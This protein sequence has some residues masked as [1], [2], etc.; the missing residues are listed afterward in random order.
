MKERTVSQRNFLGALL[1][2]MI[3]ILAFGYLH[4]IALPPG[5]FLGVIIGWWYQEIGQ[6]AMKE[7]HQST[8]KSLELWNCLTIFVPALINKLKETKFDI[9]PYIKIF[10]SLLF[11]VIWIL[12]RPIACIRWLKAHPMNRAYSVKTLAVIMYIALNAVWIVSLMMCWHE[13]AQLVGKES[14]MPLFYFLGIGTITMMAIMPCALFSEEGNKS[15]TQKF[16]LDWERY[17][18][19]G[20]FHFFG[21]N[22]LCL[23]KFEISLMFYGIAKLSWFIGVGGTFVLCIIA[24]ISAVVGAIKGIYHVSTKSGHWLC[25]GVT[26]TVSTLS[27]WFTYPYLSDARILWTVALFAGIISTVITEITR[28]FLVWFFDT[29]EKIRI[30][31]IMSLCKRLA[32]IRQKFWRIT[33]TTDNKLLGMLPST[34][35]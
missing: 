13:Y 9:D 25:F 4:P 5:C 35:F 17:A 11:P 30:M 28:R 2:G 15:K 21:E 18:A 22:L 12:R 20:P 6:F 26:I 32:P 16:Y 14:I 34:I 23:F 31:T 24:P 33:E 3:G 7:F 27:A 8:T 19:R 1:G 29:S 10:Y